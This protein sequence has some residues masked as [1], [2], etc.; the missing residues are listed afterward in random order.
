[1][2]EELI[3]GTQED[4]ELGDLGQK[5]YGLAARNTGRPSEKQRQASAQDDDAEGS[6]EM[7][8]TP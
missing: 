7:G 5:D 8:D 2:D 1:M 4:E 6:Q 3:A